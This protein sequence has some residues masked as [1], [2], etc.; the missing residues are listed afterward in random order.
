M[1]G[2]L[3]GRHHLHKNVS[4]VWEGGEHHLHL[5]QKVRDSPPTC[6]L[7]RCPFGSQGKLGQLGER[8]PFPGQLTLGDSGPQ[9]LPAILTVSPRKG[10]IFAVSPKQTR[11]DHLPHCRQ[12]GLQGSTEGRATGLWG[13][14]AL[15]AAGCPPGPDSD[16]RRTTCIYVRVWSPAGHLRVGKPGT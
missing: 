1:F 7:L 5:L 16:D 8:A 10:H 4:Q 13:L 2:F 9:G 6:P 12:R 11:E 3:K 15:K 14:Q